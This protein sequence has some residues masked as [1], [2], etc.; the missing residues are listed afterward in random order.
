VTTMGRTVV[1]VDGSVAARYA[2][3][4]AAADVHLRP[5]RLHLL[6]ACGWP[7]V[8][9][10]LGPDAYRLP[11]SARTRED[12]Y[13]LAE[14]MLADAASLVDPEIPVTTEISS[15]LPGRALLAASET[16]DTVVV[17]SRGTGG[18]AGLLLGS[19][20]EQVAS[21]GRCPVVVVR[22][23]PAPHGPVVVG[24]DGSPA[25]LAALRYAADQAVARGTLLRA[26]HAW[27]WPVS[28]GPGD[29]VPVDHDR[30]VPA[31]DEERVLVEALAG[32]GAEFPDLTVER[33]LIHGRAAPALL[34]AGSDAALTVVGSHG[35]G[36]FTGLLVGSVSHQVLHHAA[37]PV[38]VV[39]ANVH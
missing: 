33:R 25:S 18:F 8:D 14:K 20:A 39:H 1:G 35:R 38:A 29:Q 17:G 7:L 21:H 13:A 10:P 24:I 32:L 28:A 34:S 9:L 27:R 23:A 26:V 12:V 19:V 22:P 4:W 6:H 37:G 30:A 2:L 16:A 11:A 31:V 36:G 15:D 5:R 3:E